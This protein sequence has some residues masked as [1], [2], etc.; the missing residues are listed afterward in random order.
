[1]L[2]LLQF[3]E[4]DGSIKAACGATDTQT[5]VARQL[6]Y[7]TKALTGSCRRQIVAQFEENRI[8]F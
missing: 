5:S 3:P 1:M 6:T 8:V 4:A 2:A 7:Y